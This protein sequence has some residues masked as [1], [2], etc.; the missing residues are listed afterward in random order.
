MAERPNRYK[1]ACQRAA[2]TAQ[3]AV[4]A[5]NTPAGHPLAGALTT[6]QEAWASSSRQR[7]DYQ[8][9]LDDV[10]HR[11]ARAFADTAT[12]LGHT[13]AAEPRTVDTDDPS[14][15]WK[16]WFE[17]RGTGHPRAV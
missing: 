14:Q 17:T 6:L 4:D 15:A 10:S 12:D 1:A 16:A 8:A 5:L 9:T 13:A 3:Q 2:S 7:Q 11:L